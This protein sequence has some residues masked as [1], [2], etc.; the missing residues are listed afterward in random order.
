MYS[1]E[2]LDYV[3]EQFSE[4]VSETAVREALEKMGIQKV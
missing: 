1:K 4:G 3:K 2:Q